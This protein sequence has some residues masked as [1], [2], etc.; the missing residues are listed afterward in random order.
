MKKNIKSKTLLTLL[1][2]TLNTSVV[3]AES[4][5]IQTD[6]IEIGWF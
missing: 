6:M 3:F 5:T 1:A 4:K 2:L